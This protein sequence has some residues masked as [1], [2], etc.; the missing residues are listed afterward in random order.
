VIDDDGMTG[1]RSVRR[2]RNGGWSETVD[3]LVAEE[4]L[5]IRVNDRRFTVTMRTPGADFDLARGLLFAE[6]VIGSADDIGAMR[7]CEPE[8]DADE[9]GPNL[10]VVYT[11]RE[12]AS[13]AQ[14][15]R[16]LI[17]GTSCGLCG[18]AAIESVTA[19]VRPIAGEASISAG[20]LLRLPALLRESQVIFDQTGGLH[21]AGLFDGT[22]V[23]RAAAEDIG[24]HNAVDKVIGRGLAEGW[25]PWAADSGSL[26]LLISG[27]A[28][29]EIVQKALVARIPIVAAVSAASTLAVDL[30]I[31]NNQTLVGFLR[32][33]GMTVYANAGRVVAE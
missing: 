3:C 12:P 25:L 10:V 14:W 19:A 22:G 27:R 9:I 29:F 2:L 4:P 20:L 33:T 28:S 13:D 26:T 18:K 31:A 8:D 15:Q 24:R 30:A 6:G 21:G 5:E 7:Y 11:W 32:E 23:C 16:N 1:S 17:S